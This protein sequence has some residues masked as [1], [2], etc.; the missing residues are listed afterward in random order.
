MIRL[1]LGAAI[2]GGAF[3]FFLEDEAPGQGLETAAI[4]ATELP[5]YRP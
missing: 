4:V 2:I 3:L 5:P 1:A